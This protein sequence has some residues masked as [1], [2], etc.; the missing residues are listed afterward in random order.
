MSRLGLIFLLAGCGESGPQFLGEVSALTD[1]E[2]NAQEVDA[3]LRGGQAGSV[4]LRGRIGRVCEEG[5]WFY[6]MGE[7]GLLYVKLDLATGLVLPAKSDGREVL[8]KGELVEEGSQWLLQGES[9]V[10][11]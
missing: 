6:L 1:L 4:V 3:A 9:V 2:A 5:C 7:A 8:V 11:F 10:L